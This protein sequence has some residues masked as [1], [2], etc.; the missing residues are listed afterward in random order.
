[1]MWVLWLYMFVNGM[2]SLV[3][4]A[5]GFAS[6]AEP[7]PSR[8]SIVVCCYSEPDRYVE[9]SLRSLAEQDAVSMYPESFELIFATSGGCSEGIARRYGFSVL[10]TPRGKLV[11]RHIATLRASGDIVVSAD[12]DTF[13]PPS[14][15]SEVLKPFRDPS[16]VAVSAPSVEGSPQ[17][18]RELV[19]GIPKH[20]IY[21]SKMSGRASAFRRWAYIAIGGFNTDADRVYME[22]GDTSV[23][24]SEEEE[25]LRKRLEKLGRIAYVN[26][27]AIHLGKPHGRGLHAG[28][29]KAFFG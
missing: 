9:V 12:A 13:Y 20:L 1:M 15:L 7:P 25:N 2:H 11:S 26:T 8:V 23:L 28:I 6:P 14:W 19:A 16:V 24:V 10:R 3:S 18:L 27:P 21:I 5:R 17:V 22:T 29:Q 4:V